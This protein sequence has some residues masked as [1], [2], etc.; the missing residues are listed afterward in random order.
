MHGGHK[1]VLDRLVCGFRAC[2][3]DHFDTEC[4]REL[5]RSGSCV[6][7]FKSGRRVPANL[8]AQGKIVGG[9]SADRNGDAGSARAPIASEHEPARLSCAVMWRIG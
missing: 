7:P 3:S 9:L 2:T 6:S 5:G 8:E 1:A 4:E